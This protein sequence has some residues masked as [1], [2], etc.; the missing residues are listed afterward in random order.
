[1]TKKTMYA[2]TVLRREHD[3][4]LYL[5]DRQE[6]GW[7][8]GSILIESEQW[9]LDWYQVRLGTWT[10]DDHGEC[11]PVICVPRSEQPTL[12]E[13]TK[14]PVPQSF[15]SYLGVSEEA[16][17]K[18][19]SRGNDVPSFTEYSLGGSL[20]EGLPSPSL[21]AVEPVPEEP[22]F[23]PEEE[24]FFQVG[25]ESLGASEHPSSRSAGGEVTRPYSMGFFGISPPP[26]SSS[27]GLGLSE[28]DSGS[29][30][31]TY[32]GRSQAWGRALYESGA[33]EETCF[34]REQLS[35]GIKQFISEHPG[36]R[37]GLGSSCY[38]ALMPDGVALALTPDG[39]VIPEETI[40]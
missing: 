31:S 17:L 19:L 30:F 2:D 32:E 16:A 8:V 1:M 36:V 37:L 23:T 39:T 14:S 22:A 29:K 24:E 21:P 20:P 11:C 4:S 10:R 6:G 33:L 9:L 34:Q 12:H 28:S 27:D 5:M 40:H 38:V 26:S 35:E 7:E 18:A 13:G 15:A 3:G 25:V